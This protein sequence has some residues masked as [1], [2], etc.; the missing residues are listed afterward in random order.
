METLSQAPVI[1]IDDPLKIS[2]LP[3][4]GSRSGRYEP[5]IYLVVRKQLNKDIEAMTYFQH[6]THSI[7]KRVLCSVL[8]QK[9]TLPVLD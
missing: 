6:I 5:R 9:E 2:M 1:A 4:F 3:N 7:V 8:I